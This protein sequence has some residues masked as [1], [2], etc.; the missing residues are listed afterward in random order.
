M[1]PYR[2]RRHGFRP[3]CLEVCRLAG[4]GSDPARVRRRE[5][6]LRAQGGGL[7]QVWR[8]QGR[9]LFFQKFPQ[10]LDLGFDGGIG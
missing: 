9:G 10:A 7:A 8:R 1:G 6:S 2:V 5:R 3:L 4:S